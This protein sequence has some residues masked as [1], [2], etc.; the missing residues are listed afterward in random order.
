MTPRLRDLGFDVSVAVLSD[1]NTH[2]ETTVR[3]SG[4]PVMC[5]RAA[6]RYSP[7]HVVSLRRLMREADL[8][9]VHLL[10][11]QL[12]AA[13]ARSLLSVP[14]P[15]ITSEH[16]SSNNRRGR[17]L[18]GALD[19]V[20]YAAYDAVICNSRATAD[21]LCEWSPTVR[22]RI[23]VIPNGVDVERFRAATAASRA[24]ILGGQQGPIAIFV[25]RMDTQKDHAKLLR[26]RA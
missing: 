25:A 3:A 18:V 20:M 21:A 24:D 8:V 1:G 5:A 23:T 16:G 13:A 6:H 4:V 11:S 9:H 14:A 17:P 10:P 2:L 26:A 15:L 22:S 7:M 12:W 19:R